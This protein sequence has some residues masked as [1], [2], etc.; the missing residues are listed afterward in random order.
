MEATY[1]NRK[2]GETA[3][4]TAEKPAFKS[5]FKAWIRIVAFVVVAV[6][7]PEQV[8]QAAQYDWHVIWRQPAVSSILTPSSPNNFAA[9]DIPLAI[10]NILRDVANKPINAIKLSPNLTIQLEKPLNISDQRIEEIYNWLKGKPCGSQA[11]FDYLNHKNA[12]AVE[13]D[14]AVMALTVDILNDVVRPEGNPEVIK[15]SLYALSKTS[16]YFGHKLFSAK[17]NSLTDATA[18]FIAHL[19]GDHYV[20]I[21]KISEGK[22][23]FVSNHKEEFL[24]REKFA[25]QFSGYALIS[26]QASS[27]RLLSDSEAKQIMGAGKGT[28][29]SISANDGSGTGNIGQTYDVPAGFSVPKI[30]S[31]SSNAI[32]PTYYFT[33]PMRVN[34]AGFTT[35]AGAF[36]NPA[37][38]MYTEIPNAGQQHGTP[39]WFH[40]GLDGISLHPQ[41]PYVQYVDRT[42]INGL[43]LNNYYNTG[44]QMVIKD[45]AGTEVGRLDTYKT[46]TG[47]TFTLSAV[48][49]QAFVN[50]NL[51][52]MISPDPEIRKNQSVLGGRQRQDDVISNA[53][54]TYNYYSLDPSGKGYVVFAM[55]K[56]TDFFHVNYSSGAYVQPGDVLYGTNNK[57]YI[58]G[59]GTSKETQDLKYYSGDIGTTYQFRVTPQGALFG[60][61]KLGDHGAIA[62]LT[63]DQALAPRLGVFNWYAQSAGSEIILMANQGYSSNG[64]I[65]AFT[66]ED[67]PFQYT[68]GQKDNAIVDTLT[69]T[70]GTS[71]TFTPEGVTNTTLGANSGYQTGELAFTPLK[72]LDF[73]QEK[74]GERTYAM[75]LLLTNPGDLYRAHGEE[76]AGREGVLA[77]LRDTG[78]VSANVNLPERQNIPVERDVTAAT[79]KGEKQTDYYTAMVTAGE[80]GMHIGFSMLD[81]RMNL[82]QGLMY[83]ITKLNRPVEFVKDTSLKLDIQSRKGDKAATYTHDFGLGGNNGIAFGNNGQLKWANIT[84]TFAYN[85][86]AIFSYYGYGNSLIKDLEN[87]SEFHIL[88]LNIKA[89]FDADANVKWSK[90]ADREM[91]VVAVTELKD[92]GNQV[93]KGITTG[94]LDVGKDELYFKRVE[95]TGSV[96]NLLGRLNINEV[97]QLRYM[98]DS[99]EVMKSLGPVAEATRGYSLEKDTLEKLQKARPNALP[100][101]QAIIDQMTEAYRQLDSDKFKK[102]Y[103]NLQTAQ[104]NYNQAEEEYAK[105]G[106][107]G[108]TP[109]A[110]TL[111]DAKKE[112]DNAWEEIGESDL[113]KHFETWNA[114]S[115][116]LMESTNNSQ[117]YLGS[118]P[119]RVSAANEVLRNL[120]SI[121]TSPVPQALAGGEENNVTATPNGISVA[122]VEF[123]PQY[124]GKAAVAY[125]GEGARIHWD[126]LTGETN[127]GRGL[128]YNVNQEGYE[129]A[130]RN[131]AKW[132]FSLP[133]K[134]GIYEIDATAQFGDVGRFHLKK[135]QDKYISGLE[136][137]LFTDV[138]SLK[139]EFSAAPEGYARTVQD[140]LFRGYA[141]ILAGDPNLYHSVNGEIFIGLPV[142]ETKQKFNLNEN[143]KSSLSYDYINENLY[144][145]GASDGLIAENNYT[146]THWV[147][148]FINL[149]EPLKVEP[150][151][152]IFLR[153]LGAG[154]EEAA[155][156][157]D[158][159]LTDPEQ[160]KKF[161]ALL[162]NN[163]AEE[164]DKFLQAAGIQLKNLDLNTFL[165]N[166]AEGIKIILNNRGAD[167]ATLL[168]A[169]QKK[170]MGFLGWSPE[171]TL[172]DDKAK[173]AWETIGEYYSGAEKDQNKFTQALAA[174]GVNV[175]LNQDGKI[176]DL[177]AVRL[178]LTGARNLP[179]EALY[180]AE[181]SM[182]GKGF[183]RVLPLERPSFT[184]SPSKSDSSADGLLVRRT[185]GVDTPEGF[186]TFA[187][188][189]NWGEDGFFEN[190]DPGILFYHREWNDKFPG[191][192]SSKGLEE[193]WYWRFGTRLPSPFAPLPSEPASPI[194]TAEIGKEEI[195]SPQVEAATIDGTTAGALE[196]N[197]TITYSQ[198]YDDWQKKQLGFND[199]SGKETSRALYLPD[200]PNERPLRFSRPG[201]F[202]I[203]GGKFTHVGQ[204]EITANRI[205]YFSFPQEGEKGEST[206]EEGAIGVGAIFADAGRRFD[207]FSRFT[208]LGKITGVG[209]IETFDFKLANGQPS[210]AKFFNYDHYIAL[211][212]PGADNSKPENWVPFS[213]GSG[214]SEWKP[215]STITIEEKPVLEEGKPVIGSDGKPLKTRNINYNA[216]AM[217]SPVFGEINIVTNFT[218]DLGRDVNGLTLN[219]GGE[220]TAVTETITLGDFIKKHKDKISDETKF[221]EDNY[222]VLRENGITS[223]KKAAVA[224][225]SDSVFYRDYVINEH[226]PLTDLTLEY[227]REDGTKVTIT[228]NKI[229]DGSGEER[230]ETLNE[231]VARVNH[232]GKLG[233]TGDDLDKIVEQNKNILTSNLGVWRPTDGTLKT[234]EIAAGP[235]YYQHPTDDNKYLALAYLGVNNKA[236]ANLALPYSW[237]GAYHNEGMPD[238][239]MK[240]FVPN[241]FPDNSTNDFIQALATSLQKQNSSGAT[242][243]INNVTT[244]T[245]DELKI[246]LKKFGLDIDAA[247]RILQDLQLNKRREINELLNTSAAGRYGQD[248][249]D[250]QAEAA[251]KAEREGISFESALEKIGPLDFQRYGIG[252]KE[253]ADKIEENLKADPASN[254]KIEEKITE[255][256]KVINPDFSSYINVVRPEKGA[257][258]DGDGKV[259]GVDATG[260]DPL[261]GQ[262]NRVTFTAQPG[263]PYMQSTLGMAGTRLAIPYQPDYPV[264]QTVDINSYKLI[265]AI[266]HPVTFM[267][268]AMGRAGELQIYDDY[269]LYLNGIFNDIIRNGLTFKTQ[270]AAR[271]FFDGGLNIEPEEGVVPDA[272]TY[273]LETNNT[274]FNS[275]QAPLLRAGG[276]L[277]E[278]AAGTEIKTEDGPVK[279]DEV[280][281]TGKIKVGG[282]EYLAAEL[283][284]AIGAE[285][286]EASSEGYFT[287]TTLGQFDAR[288]SGEKFVPYDQFEAKLI[289]IQVGSSGVQAIRVADFVDLKENTQRQINVVGEMMNLLGD[290]SKEA[291]LEQVLSNIRAEIQN[292]LAVVEKKEQ[293][294]YDNL[295]LP[296]EI[297]SWAR[298]EEGKKHLETLVSCIKAQIEDS[299]LFDTGDDYEEL[300]QRLTELSVYIREPKAALEEARRIYTE[301]ASLLERQ[302]N[303]LKA[304]LGISALDGLRGKGL[305]VPLN[306]ERLIDYAVTADGTRPA[307]GTSA[308]WF[309]QEGLDW[310]IPAGTNLADGMG[311]IQQSVTEIDKGPGL[312]P[313]LSSDYSL[314]LN[315]FYLAKSGRLSESLFTGRGTYWSNVTPFEKRITEERAAAPE[316]FLPTRTDV[317]SPQMMGAVFATPEET[318]QLVFSLAVNLLPTLSYVH[319]DSQLRF[320]K[321]D[322]FLAD[323]YAETGK[324][325]LRESAV[326]AIAGDGKKRFEDKLQKWN[327]DLSYYRDVLANATPAPGKKDTPQL[328][329]ER[330]DY[331]QLIEETEANKPEYSQIKYPDA[332]MTFVDGREQFDLDITAW[333]D[334][335][336]TIKGW[337]A[338]IKEKIDEQRNRNSFTA[339]AIADPDSLPDPNERLTEQ[340]ITQLQEQYEKLGEYLRD[341]WPKLKPDYEK[342]RYAERTLRSF[343]SEGFIENIAG[344]KSWGEVAEGRGLA[345]GVWIGTQDGED[346]LEFRGFRFPGVYDGQFHRSEIS[347]WGVKGGLYQDGDKAKKGAEFI[348]WGSERTSSILEGRV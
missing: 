190:L 223:P 243:D 322:L 233:L 329:K 27:A 53:S 40:N 110:G 7:L 148:P 73:A 261:T 13:Q 346:A 93:G 137:A 201:E 177:S 332:E 253:E 289:R 238:T 185:P 187:S 260:V 327:D 22:V 218:P 54:G 69:L 192:G 15:N 186:A 255:L 216:E 80:K 96:D 194:V 174:I 142:S 339:P 297:R 259:I 42:F 288:K 133:Y 168:N 107:I 205:P 220:N 150:R 313:L 202:T 340:G 164:T 155:K 81:G 50:E 229:K 106:A 269:T 345:K 37:G 295:N 337:M 78:G 171:R 61:P 268:S 248:Y 39:V 180:S 203:T 212:T 242:L 16:E 19:K 344:H 299:P 74:V 90:N 316:T 56:P 161:N 76:L 176:D 77:Y 117:L 132:N 179:A 207:V 224:Y 263:S 83:D 314:A 252:S 307:D 14:I 24:P 308:N 298:T 79:V 264:D 101:Q 265:Y 342:G 105:S 317:R 6:F 38:M 284:E 82:G 306:E 103:N 286:L 175:A 97:N 334:Y 232:D 225:G 128:L 33:Q 123:L 235:L 206:L 283:A 183:F 184:P 246:D 271:T 312:A 146:A 239:F 323:K 136:Y 331:A 257:I 86:D 200:L 336:E 247:G 157:L 57:Q 112:L 341:V 113:K 127:L 209:E 67:R 343:L 120:N 2:L 245:L 234:K 108:P 163:N 52:G 25:E 347:I 320:T 287:Q 131:Q 126:P 170:A 301:H 198:K 160:E 277:Y 275:S 114:G 292:Y 167:P 75:P 321:G 156:I 87:A 68:I 139:V 310:R 281:D 227:T 305:V 44:K 154:T 280:D 89:A 49:S 279:I 92:Q 273:K 129:V 94:V 84:S 230:Y 130:L 143:G 31:F 63:T 188:M 195:E 28:I 348:S 9:I 29:H 119:V 162:E 118:D 23:Y 272:G 325:H 173:A 64:S 228:I 303:E 26:S 213:L 311:V 222:Q 193:L 58:A 43:G 172:Q 270:K 250:L 66:P 326:V 98:A 319:R 181:G 91:P 34:S 211:D 32:I 88:G 121:N 165:K 5:G 85:P 240:M 256:K 241:L 99:G 315:E 196:I 189:R 140:G 111:A 71:I 267:A 293:K 294:V 215:G 278:I 197:E 153:M 60:D 338:G 333:E 236:G 10:K 221:L 45:V 182:L 149:G 159:I 266:T 249:L 122:G 17:I 328:A 254:K 30:P 51:K 70:K 291:A 309:R 282:K 208:S 219:I 35:T 1:F 226:T 151:K 191:G 210:S 169:D 244:A 41:G 144:M 285:L 134:G 262:V 158:V 11:L 199:I 100:E 274:V 109:Q 65:E 62:N 21:S 8:A 251:V 318:D 116:R 324:A 124:E 36:W 3:Q 55:T 214:L 304:H 138:P 46:S 166:A 217:F 20:L 276:L 237:G 178:V 231:A 204:G 145:R 48:Q 102:L 59:F 302:E 300:A 330:A 296:A 141:K 152:N 47:L 4:P 258:I 335:G 72:A 12:Q 95:G 147:N 135:Y 290:K 115:R 18:P 104:E 125:L